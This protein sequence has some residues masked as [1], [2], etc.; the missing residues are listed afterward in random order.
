MKK[1]RDYAGQIHVLPAMLPLMLLLLYSPMAM[2]QEPFEEPVIR[3]GNSGLEE[4]S[5][6]GVSMLADGRFR[7]TRGR[8]ETWDGREAPF[9]QPQET[10][11]DTEAQAIVIQYDWG[12]IACNYQTGPGRVDFI[13]TVENTSE[14]RILKELH[15]QLMALHFPRV[16]HGWNEH[17]PWIS[18]N[19]GG[20]TVRHVDYGF[21]TLALVNEDIHRPLITGFLWTID[22]PHN[23]V[24]PIV[25][26]TTSGGWLGGR[27]D[28][29]L[30]R[31]VLPGLIDRYHLSLRFGPARAGLRELAGD[32]LDRYAQSYPFSINWE[33]RR[34]IGALFLS[35]SPR[36]DWPPS[37]NPRGWSHGTGIDINT[38]EGRENF[39]KGLMQ[40]ADNS[41]KIA[42]DT[43]AQGIVI[44][45]LEGQQYPHATSYLGD[46]RSLPPEMDEVADEFMKKFTDA[47]LRIGLTVRPQR[48]IRTAY[49]A[50]VRQTAVD[51]P[52]RTMIDKIRYAKERWGCTLFYV[53]S[54]GDPN[55][56]M[57]A[58]WF[59]M[60]HQ[61]HPDVLLMPEQK[62]LGYYAYTAP[63]SGFQHSRQPSTSASVRAVYPE[64][65]SAIYVADGPVEEMRDA[66]V[67][68]VR[69]GDILLF[70]SWFGDRYNAMVKSIYEEAY[71]E[72]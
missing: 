52:V 7:V 71:A 1:Y 49:Q 34:P 58:G 28:E 46:P 57:P 24:R 8:L 66:L 15:L 60:V 17:M 38:E 20:L 32:A 67:E 26:Q 35:S 54:N 42:L 14:D 27:P 40:V 56:A 64:A 69:R 10:T 51:D 22:K 65:F 36:A 4:L 5:V 6:N 37:G 41:I 43:G 62:T 13:V 50:N 16:M 31:E 23:L 44:W 53:D 59:R 29:F 63:Y 18:H 19:I 2:A 25:I 61:A 12:R 3:L 47:G 48:P 11:L 33:D 55:V 30:K 39:R 45:D 21:G 68:S 70:R 72:K 9:T